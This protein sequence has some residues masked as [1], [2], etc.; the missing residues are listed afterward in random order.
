MPMLK[1]LLSITVIVSAAALPFLASSQETVRLGTPISEDQLFN[2]YLESTN[3]A[4]AISKIAGIKLCQYYNI[5]HNTSYRCLMPTNLYGPNDNYNL[6]TSHVIPALIRKIYE[7][8]LS[9]KNKVVIWGSGEAQREFLHVDDLADAILFIHERGINE[10]LINIGS[11][12]EISIK[13]L[14]ILIQQIID[15]QGELTF[16]TKMPDGNPRKLLDSSK[17]NSLGWRSK[18]KLDQGIKE[19]YKWYIDEFNDS[20]YQ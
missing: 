10:D 7:A 19:V 3:E 2:G 5:K 6:K 15:Y 9:D 13:N 11:G 4:Y 14:S 1:K 8:K 16:D 20:K 18:I 17:I 12:E